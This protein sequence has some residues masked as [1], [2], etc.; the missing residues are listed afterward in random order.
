[1]AF[2]VSERTQEIGIRMALGASRGNV[3]RLIVRQ[4]AMLALI[5]LGIGVGG[6]VLVGREMQNTLYGVGSLDV[7]VIA[8]VATVLFATALFASYLPARRA[9]SIDP[10]QALRSE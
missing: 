8:A 1:M 7:S 9:A 3:A 10:M 6:A 4:G 5:G 2:T